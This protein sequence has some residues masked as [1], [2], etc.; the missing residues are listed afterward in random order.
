[1]KFLKDNWLLFTAI[2]LPLLLT[3]VFFIATQI[4]KFSIDPPLHSVVFATGYNYNNSN[5]P[6]RLLIK[7][8]QLYFKYYP[9]HEE[10]NFHH[11]KKPRLFIYNP[12]T[13]SQQEIELPSIDDPSIQLDLLVRGLPAKKVSALKV[14]PDGYIFDTHYRE[15]NNLMTTL[16]GG[17]YRSRSEVILTKGS[18]RVS[19]H[20]SHRY[21]TYFIGWLIET[22]K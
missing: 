14:S 4:D 6:Y 3:L 15:I 5:N 21:N 11:W 18:H 9:P 17:G 7:D 2:F 13:E 20:N 19:I 10:N 22:E 1:M 16:F 8:H 12:L